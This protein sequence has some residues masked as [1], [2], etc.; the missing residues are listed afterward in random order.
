MLPKKRS[1]HCENGIEHHFTE[2]AVMIAF[3]MHLIDEGSLNVCI[4]PDGEHA[5]RHDILQT[6]AANGFSMTSSL[7]TTSYGGQFE[8]N[9]HLLTVSPRSGIGDVTGFLNGKQIVAECKG[10]ITN[11]KH[12]GQTSRLRKG[13]CEVIGQLISRELGDE[14][15]IAVVPDTPTT[16]LLAMKMLSRAAAANIEIALIEPTGLIHFLNTE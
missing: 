6:L 9:T 8:R 10:G 16:R 14:R 13:L 11:T 5:K 4:H 7:G 2:A 12:P 15:H 1:K 3:A